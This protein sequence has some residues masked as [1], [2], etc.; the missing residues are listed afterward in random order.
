MLPTIE[1][2]SYNKEEG[3]EGGKDEGRKGGKKEGREGGKKDHFI[4]KV[5][6]NTFLTSALQCCDTCGGYLF[7][8]YQILM[9]LHQSLGALAHQKEKATSFGKKESSREYEV[10]SI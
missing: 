2:P 9:L 3:R 1:A 5:M 8:I 4:C 10:G 7:N 6:V